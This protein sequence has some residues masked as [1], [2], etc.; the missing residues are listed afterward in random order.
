MS[1]ELELDGQAGE[2]EPVV[3]VGRYRLF[4]TESGLVLARAVDTCERCQGCGCGTQADPLPLPD[5]RRGR[6]HLLGWMATNANKGLMRALTG[7]MNSG[8]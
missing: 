2:L 7:V 6:A 5:P 3:E 4:Q 1:D 8:D